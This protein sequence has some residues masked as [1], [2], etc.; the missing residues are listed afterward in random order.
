MRCVALA[1]RSCSLREALLSIGHRFTAR[2]AARRFGLAVVAAAAFAVPVPA[3]VAAGPAAVV[4]AAGVL[5]PEVSAGD[6]IYA[7][8]GTACRAEVNVRCDLQIR[9][10]GISNGLSRVL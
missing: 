1:A 10:P 9:C 3:A 8:N 6:M 5:R 7:G 4:P 2:L